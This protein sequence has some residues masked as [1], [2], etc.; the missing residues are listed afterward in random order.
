MYPKRRVA[1]VLGYDGSRYLGMQIQNGAAVPT[2]ESELQ[3]AI[4]RAGLV[5]E[6]NSHDLGKIHFQRCARTDR[7]VSA[8]AQ[9]V[10][11]NMLMLPDPV[12]AI[13]AHLPDDIRVWDVQRTTGSFNAKNACSGREYLYVLPTFALAPHSRAPDAVRR[14]TDAD[15]AHGNEPFADQAIECAHRITDED[16]LQLRS[17]LHAYVGTHNFH[18][19]TSGRAATD[20]SC[21]RHITGFGAGDPFVRDGYEWITLA[22]S[23]QSFML[24]QIRK[25]VGLAVAIMR[26]LCD[27]SCIARAFMPDKIDLPR[28]PGLG[29]I[30]GN[31]FFYYYNQTRGKLH[32]ELDWS[33]VPEV[34]RAMATF[35]DERL[36][37]KIAA[38]ERSDRTVSRW[39]HDLSV[40]TFEPHLAVAPVAGSDCG[41][42]TDAADD[43]A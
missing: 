36:I 29:L 15:A 28:A 12:A 40:H 1:M 31:V 35:R 13:N 24:H 17:I 30:L 18:N 20:S 16:V 7:G 41:A 33:K 14:P 11:L 34:A 6:D 37:A 32:G 4:A 3:R 39:L 21:R 5:S 42:P 10:S 9:V 23:G 2:I 19:F 27:A 8:V 26:G 25:M 38:T 43:D 22:V